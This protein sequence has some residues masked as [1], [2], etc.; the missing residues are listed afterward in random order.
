MDKASLQK[1]WDQLHGLARYCPRYPDDILV[2][3]AFRSFPEREP[4]SVRV[5]DLGCGAGRNALFLAREGFATTAVD[6]SETG[7]A[8]TLQRAARESLGVD[9]RRAAVDEIDFPEAHFDGV[10]CYG[11]YCYAPWDEIA[12]SL[13]RVAHCLAPGG[14]FYCMTRSDA[15]W[16]R[17]R[18][19]PVGRSRYR[20]SGL[21][22][23]THA[24][25][26]EELEMTFL[27][28]ADVR[29]LFA[30]FAKLELDRRT[31]S[32]FDRRYTD[33]D[34]LIQAVR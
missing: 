22:E 7:V 2:R 31:V 20:L 12:R 4:G 6:L 10:V 27:S 16:R 30:P 13:E 34:W 32:W 17:K 8:T 23:D 9:A 11:V 21:D 28:E 18:G 3:W 15:D 24:G 1:R 5:L 14:R 29:E 33:D 25:A 19:T 26:E